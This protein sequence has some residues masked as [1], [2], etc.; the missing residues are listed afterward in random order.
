MNLTFF[1]VRGSTPCSSSDSKRYGGNTSCVVLDGA[2]FEPIVFDLGTGLR[3]YGEAMLEAGHPFQGL[4]LVTH[5]HWD[6][7]QGLPF[8][9]SIHEAGAHL[10]IV[11]PSHDDRPIAECFTEFMR[12]PYFPISLGHLAG[13]VTF[14]DLHKGSFAHGL[15]TV[16]AQPVPHVGATNGYRVDAHGASVAY[17]SDHQQPVD[18]AT[19]VDRHV[20]ELARDVDVLIHDAQ[21]TPDEF[22][23]R[24]TWGHCTIEYA[25]EVALQARAKALVL[26]HHDPLH[27]DVWMDDIA[28]TTADVAAERGLRVL[29]AHEGMRL[30]LSAGA[31][32]QVV[33]AGAY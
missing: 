22:A 32:V 12:P 8:F 14:R 29:T 17:I 26:F 30:Q 7:V 31:P 23:E 5:L 20:I 27:D 2:G 16:M 13:S 25:I 11:G 33:S 3:Y 24:T 4:A 10:E 15:A 21:Y 19:F 18:D 6:H 9:R 28:A 1:G